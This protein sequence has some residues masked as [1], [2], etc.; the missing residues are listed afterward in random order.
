M[1]PQFDDRLRAS[2]LKETQLFFGELIREDR[3]IL[4][5]ID[6]RYT[7][8]NRPLAELY[9]LKNVGFAGGGGRRRGGERDEFVRVELPADSPRGGILTQASVLTVTS[10]PTRHQPGEAREV[11]AGAN[12]RHAAAPATAGRARTEE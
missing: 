10:N 6:G 2:M 12:P 7:Y 1:F 9:G 11:G 4:D 3:P 5:L 8:V